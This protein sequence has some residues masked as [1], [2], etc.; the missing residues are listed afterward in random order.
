MVGIT[1]FIKILFMF[2][3]VFSSSCRTTKQTV[4]EEIIVVNFLDD[5]ICFLV[6]DISRSTTSEISNIKLTQTTFADGKIKPHTPI[7]DNVSTLIFKIY[8]SDN[9]SNTYLLEHPLF[10]RMEHSHEENG[11]S[12]RTVKL[13]NSEFF[14]RIPINEK[15]KLLTISESI[16]GSAPVEIITYKFLKK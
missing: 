7:L 13:S 9:N 5:K 16:E 14:M 4:M 6:F 3:L 1:H 2:I 10:R 8:D 11:L 15:S 12:T